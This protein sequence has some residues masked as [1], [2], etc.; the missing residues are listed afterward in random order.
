[1]SN[2]ISKSARDLIGIDSP[3]RG[4]VWAALMLRA[5]NVHSDRE[6]DD[7]NYPYKNAVR[8]A[9]GRQVVLGGLQSFITIEATLPYRSPEALA[10]GGDFLPFVGEYFEG[11]VPGY[12]GSACSTLNSLGYPYSGIG[13]GMPPDDLDVDSLEKYLV[14]CVMLGEL[15]LLSPTPNALLPISLDFLEEAPG[16]ASL[17]LSAKL[18][19]DYIGYRASNN[20]VCSVVPPSV[21]PAVIP[22]PPDELEIEW[23]DVLNKPNFADVA[24]SGDYDD[25]TNRPTIPTKT[26]DLENDLN[27]LDSVDYPVTSVNGQTGAVTITAV[28]G[29]A[30][31]ENVLNKPNFAD[32][33][34]SGDY[35]DLINPPTIPTKTSEL[36][37]DENFLTE[38]NYPVT[39]VN[40]QTG[41]VVLSLGNGG[42]GVSNAIKILSNSDTLVVKNEYWNTTPNI[43]VNLPETGLTNYDVLK[44]TNIINTGTLTLQN[45]YDSLILSGLGVNYLIYLSQSDNWKIYDNSFNLV[46]TLKNSNTGTTLIYS[47]FLDQNGLF[48]YLGTNNLTTAWSNP[49]PNKVFITNSG[50]VG[51]QDAESYTDRDTS[52]LSPSGG[53]AGIY[54]T[55]Q[56]LTG[57][58]FTLKRYVLQ[59]VFGSGS[60]KPLQWSMS[61]SNDGSN[62]TVLHTQ[63]TNYNWVSNNYNYLSPLLSNNLT[64]YSYYKLAM[65]G[66]NSGNGNNMRFSEIEFYGEVG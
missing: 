16:G 41:D 12:T 60:D 44:V 46:K 45:T 8:I 33:A 30:E 50:A 22:P 2:L 24:I 59:W 58:Q 9:G 26:S 5:G 53:S 34:I 64:A 39:S 19:I 1:M 23:T 14:W 61:G 51:T 57:I 47:N 29:E 52:V 25:I 4:M 32:V 65:I 55:F 62:W 36:D 7:P 11:S 13:E 20:L 15:E 43:I 21:T 40:G 48:Y 38:V 54:Q 35:A 49:C 31:W 3:W 6:G 37:N 56:L 66:L 28:I 27:F 63:N 17:K 18:F 10:D 42:N